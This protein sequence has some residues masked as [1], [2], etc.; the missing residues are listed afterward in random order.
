[1]NDKSKNNENETLLS[2]FGDGDPLVMKQ[3]YKDSFRQVAA[4]V[5]RNSGSMDDAKD[6]FQ[7]AMV[8]LF[9][10]VRDGKYQPS[11]SISTYIYAIARYRWINQLKGKSR[12]A[13]SPLTDEENVEE[14]DDLSESLEQSRKVVV[15]TE[16]LKMLTE[17]ERKLIELIGNGSSMKEISKEMEFESEGY[18][19]L[20]RLRVF[21]K[22]K[23]RIFE[24][25]KKDE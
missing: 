24:I 9:Q 23:Y 17:R 3:V 21:E 13:I 11:A 5:L 22:L 2:L 18:A 1:M 25:A 12:L 15:L 16:A 6:I 19:R 7:E 20:Y 10:N 4:M 14:T 8:S